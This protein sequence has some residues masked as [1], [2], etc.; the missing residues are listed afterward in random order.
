MLVL[1]RKLHEKILL[2]DCQTTVEV[3]AIKSGVVRLGIHA[4]PHVTVLREELQARGAEWGA[5]QMPP[6]DRAVMPNSQQL[7]HFLR[8]QLNATG[9]ALALLHQQLLAGQSQHAQATLVKLGEDFELLRERLESAGEK[10]VPQPAK[11]PRKVRKALLVEDNQ[12]ERE[13]LAGL[14]RMAGV[15]VDTAGDGADA[16]DYLRT[17]ALPD[18]MLL[19]MAMPRCDGPTTVRAIRQDPANALLKIFAVSGRSPDE[20]PVESGPAGIN[21]WFCKPID[22]QVLIRALTRELD[23]PLNGLEPA[24]VDANFVC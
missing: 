19:D 15:D 17:T 4:P 8:G 21:G 22:P 12:N 14:L 2:P 5:A 13:L 16:L 10:V 6:A 9:L 11:Q 20:F 3:V 1:S 7:R 23:S 18:V 24:T